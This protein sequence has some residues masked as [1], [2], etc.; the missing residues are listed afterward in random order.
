[1]FLVLIDAITKGATQLS[2]TSSYI[3]LCPGGWSTPE[4]SCVNANG[5]IKVATKPGS[6]AA[7]AIVSLKLASVPPDQVPF[8]PRTRPLTRGTTAP[9]CSTAA[10]CTKYTPKSN[11]IESKPQENTIRAPL[12]LACS[13]CA[14]IICFIQAGSP[15]KST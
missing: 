15:H 13:P 1:M 14:S 4:K 10:C 5:F 9:S 12:T 11:G 7:A 8:I 3:G 6:L 2:I